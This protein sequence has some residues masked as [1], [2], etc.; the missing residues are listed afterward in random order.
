MKYGC[1]L[2]L[3][4]QGHRFWFENNVHSEINLGYEFEVFAVYTPG[5]TNT[6]VFFTFDLGEGQGQVR[7]QKIL[8]VHYLEVNSDMQV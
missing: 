6:Q 4:I 8:D 5:D 3:Q 2:E 7:H 1:D